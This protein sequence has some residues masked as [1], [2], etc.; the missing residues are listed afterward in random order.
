[1]TGVL[2]RTRE[3]KTSCEL[4][5]MEDEKN[6]N[7]EI[8]S[9]VWGSCLKLSSKESKDFSTWSFS[10][11]LWTLKASFHLFCNKTRKF[12]SRLLGIVLII[13]EEIEVSNREQFHLRPEPHKGIKLMKQLHVQVTSATFHLACK[14]VRPKARF[15]LEIHVARK[16]S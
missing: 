2:R 5:A 10:W 4:H 6:L 11:N 8:K 14:W 9:D 15:K 12:I 7:C 1:M 13:W 3:L 16:F